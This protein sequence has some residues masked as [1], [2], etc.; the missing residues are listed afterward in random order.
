MKYVWGLAA[1]FL[2]L[3]VF[4]GSPIIYIMFG[5]LA[6]TGTYMLTRKVIRAVDGDK[7]KRIR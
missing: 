7:R 5:V 1:L 2:F 6:G 3:V 4:F